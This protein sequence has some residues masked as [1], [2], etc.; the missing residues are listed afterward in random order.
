[1]GDIDLK[2]LSALPTARGLIARHAYARARK[3]K[4][5]LAPLLKAAGLTFQQIEDQDSRIVNMLTVQLAAELKGTG[6]NVNSADPGF[7]GDRPIFVALVSWFA[8]VA[9]H[10]W[11]L[12]IP[13]WNILRGP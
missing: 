9:T 13:A 4:I 5:G 6:V 3:F 8:L 7:T 2:Q 12:H 10:H 11:L 1:V